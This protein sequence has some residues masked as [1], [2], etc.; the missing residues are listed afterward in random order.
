MREG[1]A[2]KD[3]QMDRQEGRRAGRRRK[4]GKEPPHTHIGVLPLQTWLVSE[5][6][7]RYWCPFPCGLGL[8]LIELN[9]FS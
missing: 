4:E 8:E 9:Q 2:E 3:R 1:A 6:C 5:A 7:A